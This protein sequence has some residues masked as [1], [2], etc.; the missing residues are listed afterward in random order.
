MQKDMTRVDGG[1]TERGSRGAHK[2]KGGGREMEAR[3]GVNLTRAKACGKS[4]R[5]LGAEC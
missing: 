4:R 3:Y 1:V 5:S 2:I